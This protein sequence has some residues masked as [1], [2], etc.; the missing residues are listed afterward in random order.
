MPALLQDILVHN[1]RVSEKE[2]PV[3]HLAAA[4]LE[5]TPRKRCAIFTCM[6]AR[7]V[8]MVE[9][10]LG[11]RRGDAV[12]LRNAGNIIG[13]PQGTMI[14]SLLVAIFMQDIEEIVV[15]GHEDCGFTHASSAVLLERVR[16]RG[17]SEE[18]VEAMRGPL[19][20]YLDPHTDPEQNVRDV[21]ELLRT[22][23]PFRAIFWSTA[24]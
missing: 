24:C 6:D 18:A 21:V 15:V 7:L 20:T 2:G 22:I 8:E 13:T 23:R 16:R 17:I 1:Q 11:I 5:K 19:E 12:V 14:I 10:A 4:S 3:R 9:P